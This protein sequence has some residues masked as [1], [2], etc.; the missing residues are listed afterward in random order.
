[1]KSCDVLSDWLHPLFNPSSSQQCWRAYPNTFGMG[2]NPL[3]DWRIMHKESLLVDRRALNLLSVFLFPW[4][5][6]FLILMT[7]WP[8]IYFSNYMLDGPRISATFWNWQSDIH[9]YFTLWLRVWISLFAIV[10]QWFLSVFY[11]NNWVQH[12]QERLFEHP[13]VHRFTLPLSVDNT[14]YESLFVWWN[15]ALTL[16]DKWTKQLNIC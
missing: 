8:L 16:L 2:V 5:L 13:T 10:T 9:I 7:L 1:M 11:V 14:S 6:T 15:Q 4:G 12:F 3:P